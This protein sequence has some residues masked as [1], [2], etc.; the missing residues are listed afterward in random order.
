MQVTKSSFWNIE[1]DY[2]HASSTLTCTV[3]GFYIVVCNLVL[4]DAGNEISF[5]SCIYYDQTYIT[6]L[7]SYA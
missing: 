7:M 6:H 3:L 4:C 1:Y 5:A 2:A